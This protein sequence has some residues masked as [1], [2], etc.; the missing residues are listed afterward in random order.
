MIFFILG[1]HMYTYIVYTYV[2]ICIHT[3][4]YIVHMFVSQL[5]EFLDNANLAIEFFMGHIA[6]AHAYRPSIQYCFLIN[7]RCS[8]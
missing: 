5:L 7:S 1:K 3:Y 4:M 2:Y 6:F 8:Y